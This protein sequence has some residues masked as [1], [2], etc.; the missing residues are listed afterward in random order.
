MARPRLSHTEL[1][2]AVKMAIAAS[3]AWAIGV[4]A[5]RVIG[6]LAGV[7]LGVAALQVSEPSLLLAI[8]VIV[9]GLA[10]GIPLGVRG[11]V[12]VQV[13]VS[14][15]IML[16]LRRLVSDLGGLTRPAPVPAV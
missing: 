1:R 14:A 4:A 16:R 9:I 5:G 13:A 12:N 11:E 7:A 6:V 2:S 15:M 8:A 10:A 3:L